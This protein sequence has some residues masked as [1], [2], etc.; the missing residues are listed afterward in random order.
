MTCNGAS[1]VPALEGIATCWP[2]G[3]AEV[4]GLGRVH[5]QCAAVLAL[6]EPGTLRIHELCRGAPDS[7]PVSL[8]S[9]PCARRACCG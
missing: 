6:H 1:R 7:Y 9:V 8:E 3:E 5:R 2:L 4:R